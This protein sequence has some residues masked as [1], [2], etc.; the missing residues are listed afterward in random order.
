[1]NGDIGVGS[2]RRGKVESIQLL[3]AIAACAVAYVHLSA[4]A[5]H[6]GAQRG[7]PFH[8][9]AVP[10]SRV[11]LFFVISGCIM[12]YSSRRYYSLHRGSTLFWS[13]RLIRTVPIYWIATLVFA[14][15]LALWGTV[16]PVRSA[17]RSFSSLMQHRRMR[18]RCRCSGRPG[19]CRSR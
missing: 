16:D 14:A 10:G 9:W 13:R 11:A 6:I 3:R 19:R 15:W 5:W 17:S 12:V 18:A 8:I 2:E 4:M 7:L 1:M